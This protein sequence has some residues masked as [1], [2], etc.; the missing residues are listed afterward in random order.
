MKKRLLSALIATFSLF[1]LAGCSLDLRAEVPFESPHSY[2]L[3]RINMIAEVMPSVVAVITET[4]HG[5]GIIFRGEPIDD[6]L[7]RYYIMTNYHVIKDG[8]EMMIHFGNIIDDIP[9]VDY[10]G[11]AAYDIA[12]VRIIT[13][14]NLRVHPVAP[15][16]NNTIT[17]ILVGQD[18]YAIGTPQ[19]LTKFNAVSQGIVSLNSYPYNGIPGLVIMH[20]A[21][22]NPGNSGGPLFNLNGELIAINVAKVSYISTLEGTIPAEGLNYSLNINTIAPIV[23]NFTED[24]YRVVERRPRLG[25]TVQEVSLFLEENDASLLPENPVGVVIINFDLTRNAHEELEVYDLI[26]KMNGVAI[27][28]IAELAAQLDGAEFGDSHEL[29]VLR[30]IGDVFEEVTVTIILS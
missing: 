18:V 24:D 13:A 22:L 7:T 9:V 27:L 19:G 4:G 8:G 17:E 12:V 6:V 14:E 5:S 28:S 26:I 2:E 3:L 29:T 11:N 23:R 30:K 1:I 10:A 21:E 16:D 25:V 15:I 20:D